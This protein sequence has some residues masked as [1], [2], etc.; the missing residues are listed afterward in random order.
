MSLYIPSVDD[1]NHTEHEI[2]SLTSDYFQQ[3]SH[4][5]IGAVFD[6]GVLVVCGGI[7]SLHIELG[8]ENAYELWLNNFAYIPILGI[9]NTLNGKLQVPSSYG[10]KCSVGYANFSIDGAEQIGAFIN[11]F[12]DI[13][14]QTYG[15]SNKHFTIDPIISNS[16]I[17][18]MMFMNRY[19]G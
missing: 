2:I 10:A 11:S 8:V 5:G 18:D 15:Y 3:P 4:G 13:C 6:S 12:N 7:S 9:K 1:G 19:E 16:I 17:I 14:F